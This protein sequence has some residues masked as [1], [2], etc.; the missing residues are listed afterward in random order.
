V[1]AFPPGKIT[2]AR[3]LATVADHFGT[4]VAALCSHVRTQPLVRR[5]QLAAFL[6]HKLTGRSLVFVGRKIGGRDHTTILN[7]VR[8]VQWRLDAGDVA[9]VDAVN[10]ITER[11]QV[12]GANV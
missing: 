9:V 7:A 5:R 8:V 12:G 4:D 10:A 11:L 2:V 6:A 1:A 3:V